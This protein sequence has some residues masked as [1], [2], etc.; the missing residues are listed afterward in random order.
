MPDNRG[1]SSRSAQATVP[2]VEIGADLHRSRLRRHR[3]VL[4]SFRGGEE[5][6]RPTSRTCALLPARSDGRSTSIEGSSNGCRVRPQNA[7][8]HPGGATHPAQLRRQVRRKHILSNC[9]RDLGHR[10]R[11]KRQ[12]PPTIRFLGR[13]SR[14]LFGLL[15]T[16]DAHFAY[17]CGTPRSQPLRCS[18]RA[19]LLELDFDARPPSPFPRPI[20]A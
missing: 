4:E 2:T 19:K 11:I 15:D 1:A 14:E 20:T 10:I 6:G 9:L 8:K 5:E 12:R 16:I 3:R 7:G 18:S 13:I 17:P